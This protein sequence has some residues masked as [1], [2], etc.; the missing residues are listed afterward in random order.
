VT[1]ARDLGLDSEPVDILKETEMAK[2]I[3]TLE[4]H[5]ASEEEIDFLRYRRVELNAMTAPVF[6][7]YLERKLEEHGVRK[8][9]PKK[10]TIEKHARRIFEQIGTEKAL[11]AVLEEIQEEA[12]TVPLPKDLLKRVRRVLRDS[13]ATSWDAAVSKVIRKWYSRRD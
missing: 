6:V 12:Q 11:K 7:S 10:F 4:R 9:L 1:D 2:R 3:A 13:P 8:F 5:G